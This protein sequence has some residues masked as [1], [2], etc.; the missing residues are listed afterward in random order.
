[1]SLNLGYA[2]A[3]TI[4]NDAASELAL[5]TA[6]IT[7][8]F[9]STDANILQLTRLLATVGRSLVKAHAWSQL[10][11]ESGFTATNGTYQ[12]ALPDDFGRFADATAWDRTNR[13]PLSGPLDGK[14][15]QKLQAFAVTSASY[16]AFRVTA[17]QFWL[18]PTPTSTR[19]I[20]YEYLSRYWVSADGSTLY[21]D[22]ATVAADICFF[23][24]TLLVRALKLAWLNAKK[25]P[26]DSEQEDYLETL[27]SVKAQDGAAGASN[28][29]TSADTGLLTLSNA[30]D[31]GY[32]T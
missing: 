26:A 15:W 2:S 1:M 23:D 17:G 7:D 27:A 5:I 29:A 11:G 16:T 22:R 24:P 3:N 14:S 8:V 20:Y 21:N 30:P 13:L 32:G 18:Y 10:R 28:L 12:Y 25:L 9:A 6:D 4:V 19:S 31:G